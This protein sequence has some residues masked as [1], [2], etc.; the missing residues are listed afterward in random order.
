[1]SPAALA[2]NLHAAVLGALDLAFS[3][4]LASGRPAAAAAPDPD[5]AREVVHTLTAHKLADAPHC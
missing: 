1:M 2:R 3:P 5:P 4:T